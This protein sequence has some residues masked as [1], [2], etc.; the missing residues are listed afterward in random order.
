M[1]LPTPPA[2]GW[3]VWE[4]LSTSLTLPRNEPADPPHEILRVPILLNRAGTYPKDFLLEELWGGE[5]F[6][7]LQKMRQNWSYNLYG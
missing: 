3:S 7:R 6:L 2:F 4:E 1:P 5:F